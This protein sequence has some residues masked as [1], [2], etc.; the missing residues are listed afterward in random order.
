MKFKFSFLAVISSLFA[1]TTN[2]QIPSGPPT[3]QLPKAPGQVLP[4]NGS[5]YKIKN[6]NSGRYAQTANAS[7]ENGATIHLYDNRDDAHFK[8]KAIA[9]K[10]GYKFQNVHSN[11]FLAIIGGSKEIYGALCQWDDAGQ[12]DINWKLEKASTGYKLKNKNSNLLAA[13]EG[14]S[15]NNEAKLIQWND[16]GQPDI[17]WQFE[18]VKQTDP[19]KPPAP[20]T[21]KKILVD[22]VLN[23]MGVSE[24]TRN[25]VDNGD[26][27]RIFG[28]IKTE[29]W[30]LN[31]DNEKKTMLASYNNMSQKVFNQLN[32]QS[33][34][35]VAFSF[36]QEKPGNTE[37][38]HVTYNISESL[39]Q[40]RKIMLVVKT[41]VGTR[42]KD[43]DFATYDC[44]KM[45]DEKESTFILDMAAISGAMGDK[46]QTIQVNTDQASSGRSMH[47][48]D[49]VI[50]FAIF[51]NTDDTHK[52]WINISFKKK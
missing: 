18:L 21:G 35:P 20:S 34:P 50:P 48:Q 16:A 25:R 33:P 8:W 22:I 3:L 5:I 42:H 52:I 11:K 41:N 44:L 30:E 6:V 4:V 26:C 45:E 13:V 51:Q 46:G 14:G 2:A 7:T 15:K 49:M 47:I 39:L 31:E 17:V 9:V 36:Y 23:N 24:A 29:I 19:P 40:Q 43:N 1:I 27:K 12:P 28:I 10:D 32:Y 37:M 38:S